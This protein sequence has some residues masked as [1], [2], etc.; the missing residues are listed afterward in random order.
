MG[1][2]LQADDNQVEADWQTQRNA[3][4]QRIECAADW[5]QRYARECGNKSCTMRGA[6]SYVE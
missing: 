6:Y 4:D 3:D 2:C 1:R 5:R